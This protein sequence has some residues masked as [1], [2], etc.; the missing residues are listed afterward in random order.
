MSTQLLVAR[1]KGGTI[2]DDGSAADI[3]VTSTTGE[4]VNLTVSFQQFDWLLQSLLELSNELYERQIAHGHLLERS[5]SEDVLLAEGFQ[6][7]VDAGT[8]TAL[9]QIAGRRGKDAPLGMGSFSISKTEF[10]RAL[11]GQCIGAADEIEQRQR[12]I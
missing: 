10:L 4:K 3:E 5:S 12:P 6:I 1:L 9:I 2:A 11:A 7:A 8:G